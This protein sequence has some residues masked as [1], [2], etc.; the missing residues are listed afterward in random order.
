KNKKKNLK[1]K[2]KKKKQVKATGVGSEVEI[3][4]TDLDATKARFR[5]AEFHSQMYHSLQLIQ[6]KFPFHFINAEGAMEEVK[7]SIEMELAYQSK[8]E[9]ADTTFDNVRR[10][11]LA[12]EIK[13]DARLQLVQRLDTYEKNHKSLFDQVIATIIREKRK[14]KALFK[15]IGQAIIRTE[16]PIFFREE[17]LAL[18]MVL[19]LLSE[20]G[21]RV[22]LDYLKDKHPEKVDPSTGVISFSIRKVLVFHV[23]FPPPKIRHAT[24]ESVD[25]WDVHIV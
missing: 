13:K 22:V 4:P 19:D 5:Y 14:R 7:K 23:S 25:G 11:P 10:I 16:N 17:G 24:A 1:K 6:K 12:G 3:R 20:R 8:A 9:L 2:K 21:Y 18:R 15:K